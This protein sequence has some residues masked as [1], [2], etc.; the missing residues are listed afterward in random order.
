MYYKNEQIKNI[1]QH[2]KELKQTR[3]TGMK[4]FFK[5]ANGIIKMNKLINYASNE[6][7]QVDQKIMSEYIYHVNNLKE[8]YEKNQDEILKYPINKLSNSL[9][10]ILSFVVVSHGIALGSAYAI[11]NFNLSST[12]NDM[13]SLFV[14]Y[15]LGAGLASMLTVPIKIIY[16]V[17]ETLTLN[18]LKKIF[19]KEKVNNWSRKNSNINRA[20]VIKVSPYFF[21]F[22]IIL[23]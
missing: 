1:K 16:F 21:Y 10:R 6:K 22:L 3:N 17:K 19:D 5:Y 8:K 12:I 18:K 11:K 2:I 13:L 15:G 20:L 7:L 4:L 9:D 23:N 14:I